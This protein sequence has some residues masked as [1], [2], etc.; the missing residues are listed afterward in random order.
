MAE[1]GARLAKSLIAAGLVDELV[2]LRSPRELGP[3]A[4][5]PGLDLTGF[6]ERE[7]EMLGA[8][9]MTVYEATR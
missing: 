7:Q 5:D 3:A 2:I 4:L 8:D 9:R 1:G 6:A